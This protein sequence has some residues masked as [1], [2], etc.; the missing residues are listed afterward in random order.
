LEERKM[1]DLEKKVQDKKLNFIDVAKIVGG[2]LLIYDPI[3]KRLLVES[4]E[5]KKLVRDA[6]G[7]MGLGIVYNVLEKYGVFDVV[8]HQGDKLKDKISGYT[9]Q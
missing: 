6:L 4:E 1:A 8:K 5:K 3:K 9:K 7:G 2:G